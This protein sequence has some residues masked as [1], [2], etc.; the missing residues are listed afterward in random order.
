M[1]RYLLYRLLFQSWLK[2]DQKQYNTL[3]QVVALPDRLADYDRRGNLVSRS[4]SGSQ[5]VLDL[6]LRS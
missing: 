1:V 3:N 5:G 2:Y 4:F 6:D